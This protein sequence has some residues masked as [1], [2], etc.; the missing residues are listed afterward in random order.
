MPNQPLTLSLSWSDPAASTFGRLFGR[1]SPRL[2]SPPFAARKSAIGFVAATL[3]GMLVAWLFWGTGIAAAGERSQGLS[4]TPGGR[5]LFGTAIA[6]GF[7]HTGWQGVQRGFATRQGNALLNKVSGVLAG[8]PSAMPPALMYISCGLIAGVA[9]GL[10]M[11]GIDDNVSI[12]IL[13]GLGIWGMLW[14]WGRLFT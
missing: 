3:V 2:P 11:G 5:A 13:S 10:E 8:E 14:A 12:P 6:P 1:H 4:W 9:E 7:A